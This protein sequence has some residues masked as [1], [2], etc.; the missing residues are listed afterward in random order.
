MSVPSHFTQVPTVD[1]S[2][3]TG[4]ARERSIVAGALRAAAQD[5]GFL[6]VTGAGVPDHLFADLTA[7]TREFFAL[8]AEV[9]QQLYIG[10]S[11][12]HRGYVPPGEEVFAGGT[13]DRKEAFD[14]ALDLPA[15]DVDHLAGNPLLGPNVWP[16]LPGF[17]ERVT[18]YYDAVLAFGRRL[19][20]GFAL[21]LGEAPDALDHLVTKPTSQLRLLHYPYDP[22]VVDAIGIGAHTDYELFTLLRPTAPGLEVLNGAGAWVD[23]PPID[24]AFVVNIGDMFEVLSNGRFVAT[25]HRVRRV[26]TERYSFPLF[27]A[28]DYDALV[29][30]LPG[31]VGPGQPPRKPLVAGE[32][33]FAQTAQSFTYLK[34]RLATGEL[35]LP[36]GSLSL[37]SFGREPA[38]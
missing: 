18:A 15:D 9:K 29:A 26:S 36:D 24:G 12:N 21:A 32:H 35:R 1:V 10:R 22:G 37:S 34:R 11:R 28:L 33:L 23:V 27:F 5:V 8:P 38:A 25:T 4:D 7:A 20:Q 16:D 2:G 17:Q 6:Y 30:P 13:A 3:L 31:F 14:L 19:L